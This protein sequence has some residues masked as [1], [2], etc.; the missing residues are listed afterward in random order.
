MPARTPLCERR[1]TVRKGLDDGLRGRDE[2]SLRKADWLGAVANPAN[3]RGLIESIRKV[4]NVFTDSTSNDGSVSHAV[5]KSE[6]P[7]I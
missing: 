1:L 6:S 5:D 2:T 4:R 7:I 3:V